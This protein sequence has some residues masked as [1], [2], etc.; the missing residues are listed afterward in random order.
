MALSRRASAGVL[1]LGFPILGAVA[2]AL[3]APRLGQSG[4]GWDDIGDAL[5]GLLFGAIAGLLMAVLAARRLS[6]RALRGSAIVTGTIALALIATGVIRYQ[7][8]MS[9][10]RK[11]A[12]EESD[13]L[14][15][16]PVSA[17]AQPAP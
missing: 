2:G 6:D 3:I 11:Q 13:R 9:T 5:G 15:R 1:Y 4:M 17:P 8:A 14:A 16:R 12:Q 7:N 10:A